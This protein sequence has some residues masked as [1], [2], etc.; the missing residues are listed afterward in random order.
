MARI[1][2][3]CRARWGDALVVGTLL[4]ALVEIWAADLESSRP[5]MTGFALLWTLPLLARRRFPFLAPSTALAAVAVE[6]LV[7]ETDFLGETSVPF[8]PLLLGSFWVFGAYNPPWRALA[9]FFGG[10]AAIA[11]LLAFSEEATMSDLAFVS[12]FAAASTLAGSALGTRARRAVMLEERA[13]ALERVREE[14]A[15]LAVEQ[16]RG[17]IAGELHD[18]IAHSI[19]V[20]TLQAGAARMMLDHDPGRAI[21]PV[22]NVEETG[23]QALAELR[24]LLGVLR[25]DMAGL[26]LEPQP[27]LGNIDALL[28]EMREAGL[29][30]ALTVEGEPGGAPARGRSGCLPRRGG[31]APARPRARRPSTD[32]RLRVVRRA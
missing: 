21:E 1:W 22:T 18:V 27:G 28:A 6:A 31:G 25:R 23:R 3:W 32:S 17:R 8:F 26:E 30:V 14:E 7:L 16:E 15:R 9:G 11:A 2:T 29:P 5:I 13:E 20:M 10:L 19:S 4:A 12:V 24:R